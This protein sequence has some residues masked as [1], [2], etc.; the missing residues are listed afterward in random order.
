MG[1]HSL[2]YFVNMF[3]ITSTF[4]NVHMLLNSLTRQYFFV[5]GR[6][7]YIPGVK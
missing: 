1:I 4:C 2:S 7:K 5:G 6:K 3:Q